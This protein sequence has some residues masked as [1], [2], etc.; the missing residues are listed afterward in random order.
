MGSYLEI[1]VKPR[2][3]GYLL[4]KQSGAFLLPILQGLNGREVP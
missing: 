1:P 4:F 2:E 3:I